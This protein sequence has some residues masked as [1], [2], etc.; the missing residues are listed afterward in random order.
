MSRRF[1]F[2]CLDWGGTL[3]SEAGPPGLPM[4]RWPEV[5]ATDGARELLEALARDG[6]T[7]CIATNAVD[8]QPEEIRAALARVGLDRHVA[9]IF[10]F[11]EI[12]ARK[13]TQ[14]FW[15]Q[16]TRRLEAAPEAVLMIGDSLEQDVI[17]PMRA[18]IRSIWFNP[19][20]LM[21]PPGAA[22]AT[23]G[24]LDE[25]LPRIAALEGAGVQG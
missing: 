13:D 7:L 8:S 22:V 3:M 23:I 10:C 24:H 21:P 17:A 5:S 11:R 2:I 18:G 14:A 12:G 6:R 15:E 1:R 25:A 19:A 4:V 9:R 20:G 16:V